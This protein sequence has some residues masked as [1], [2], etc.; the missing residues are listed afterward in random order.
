[1]SDEG[2]NWIKG[3]VFVPD[4]LRMAEAKDTPGVQRA[5]LFGEEK[6]TAGPTL[7]RASDDSD[8]VDDSSSDSDDSIDDLAAAILL[9]AAALAAAVITTIVIVKHG[10]KLVAWWKDKAFPALSGRVMKM[11]RIEPRQLLDPETEM[12][13]IGPVPTAEFSKEVGVVVGDNREDMSSDEAKKRLLLVMMAASIISEQLRKLSGARI[14]DDD[15]QALQSAM[16]K[17]TTGEVVDDLNRILGSERAVIDDQTQALF[18]EVFGGGRR[19]E[20]VY[21]PLTLDGVRKALKLPEDDDPGSDLASV[22]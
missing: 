14:K 15:L 5:L 7:F 13:V 21:E 11:L 8:E 6:G 9:A 3:E 19:V 12:A 17:L 2:G 10:P 1:M 18:V 22:R 16:S 4:G 20:G